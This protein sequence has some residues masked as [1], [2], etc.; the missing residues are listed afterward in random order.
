RRVRDHAGRAPA[1]GDPHARSGR[2]VRTGE[3]LRP[4][5]CL[6]VEQDA[7]HRHLQISTREQVPERGASGGRAPARTVMATPTR[8]TTARRCS[9][10][11][12]ATPAERLV[13]TVGAIARLVDV[14]ISV[15]VEGG[16]SDDPAAV[17]ETGAALVDAGAGGDKLGGGGGSPERPPRNRS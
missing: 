10:R 2:A 15:D 1:P 12:S 16:Y 17:A 9:I 4:E 3:L 8:R 14:P 13:A 11:R 5:P 6:R 7:R